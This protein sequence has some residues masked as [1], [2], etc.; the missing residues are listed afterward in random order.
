VICFWSYQG[1][2]FVFTGINDNLSCCNNSISFY[3]SNMLVVYPLFIFAAIS[4]LVLEFSSETIRM[5]FHYMCTSSFCLLPFLIV[6][7]RPDRIS[8]M[9]KDKA[10]ECFEVYFFLINVC[11]QESL[12]S[13]TYPDSIIDFTPILICNTLRGVGS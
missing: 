2:I 6:P 11:K 8:K 5:T 10:Q 4:Y 9:T 13:R 12:K 1:K 7:Q 3:R